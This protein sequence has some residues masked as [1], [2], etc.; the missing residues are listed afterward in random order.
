MIEGYTQLDSYR[1][2][3]KFQSEGRSVGVVE[4]LIRQNPVGFSPAF[5]P[6]Q[7]NNIYFDTP[8]L[9]CFHDNLRGVPNRWKFRVR[10][11]GNNGNEIS[12]PLLEL[13]IKKGTVGTKKTWTS[14]LSLLSRKSRYPFLYSCCSLSSCVTYPRE[15]NSSGI[16]AGTLTPEKKDASSE[17]RMS[18]FL[19]SRLTM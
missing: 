4:S 1:Y 2:E 9:N 12:Q 11:Y 19:L 7:I 10:W 14:L 16:E 13:K 3:R 6:R 17:V 15:I 5:R 8:G 18:A